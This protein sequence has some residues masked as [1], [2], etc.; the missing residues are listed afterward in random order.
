[1]VALLRLFLEAVAAVAKNR[2]R[3]RAGNKY[4][5]AL[6]KHGARQHCRARVRLKRM[7]TLLLCI[8]Y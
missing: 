4:T 3:A 1:M 6:V 5:F 8:S 2:A 7:A